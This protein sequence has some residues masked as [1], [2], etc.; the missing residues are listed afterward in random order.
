VNFYRRASALA[1][2]LLLV[3]VAALV[4]GR[5]DSFQVHPQAASPPGGLAIG[6]TVARLNTTGVDVVRWDGSAWSVVMPPSIVAPLVITETSN[7]AWVA[8]PRIIAIRG[9]VNHSLLA[10]WVRFC[11]DIVDLGSCTSRAYVLDPDTLDLAELAPDT[12]PVG[13]VEDGTRLLVEHYLADYGSLFDP[14]LGTYEELP[15]P[16]VEGG[17]SLSTSAEGLSS[18]GDSIMLS[19]FG[20]LGTGNVHGAFSQMTWLAITPTYGTSWMALS[21]DNS[22]AAVVNPRDGEETPLAGGELALYDSTTGTMTEA[23]TTNSDDLDFNP[24]WSVDGALVSFLS[25]D[26]AALRAASYTPYD[27]DAALPAAVIVY[28]PTTHLRTPLLD[29][30]VVRRQLVSTAGGGLLFLKLV[31]ASLQAHY[32]SLAGGP[33]QP[34]LADGLEHT[35]IGVPR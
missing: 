10:L 34:L 31:G 6:T 12:A 13:W 32:V 24:T 19:A 4:L 18:D 14:D 11:G 17:Y 35:A 15:I 20:A 5:S 22:L 23:I 9:S 1:I 29:R 27:D 26:A 21:P 28:D 30:D 8:Q 2:F 3:F 25:G 16:D 7:T 33:E